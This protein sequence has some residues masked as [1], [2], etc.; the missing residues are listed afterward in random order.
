MEE[1]HAG[2]CGPHQ[3]GLKLYDRVKKMD[4]I[5]HHGA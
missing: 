4:I 3:L 1:A 2:I 5:G